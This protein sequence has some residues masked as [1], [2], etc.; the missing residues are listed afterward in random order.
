MLH[1]SSAVTPNL[2]QCA[3]VVRDRWDH[4]DKAGNSSGNGPSKVRKIERV[5]VTD[6]GTA[7]YPYD[8]G[9]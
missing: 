7:K 5:L 1:G 2:L 9:K 3:D 8:D 4:G 6:K